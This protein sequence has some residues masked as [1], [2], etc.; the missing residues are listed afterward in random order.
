MT[1]PKTLAE[2]V[3]RI[4][5]VHTDRPA[6]EE[7]GSKAISYRDLWNLASAYAEEL[8]RGITSRLSGWFPY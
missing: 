1:H 3:Y 8:G 6:I 2:E 7:L 5:Q 4:V